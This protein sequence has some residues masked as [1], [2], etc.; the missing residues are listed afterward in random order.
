M[1]FSLEHS[2]LQDLWA[3]DVTLYNFSRLYSQIQVDKMDSP[4]CRLLG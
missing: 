2:K 3:P 1:K 4:S